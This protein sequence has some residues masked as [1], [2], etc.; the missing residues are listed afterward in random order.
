MLRKLRAHFR[1]I[2]NKLSPSWGLIVRVIFCFATGVVI[3]LAS[4]Q[5]RFD[6]RFNI[7]GSQSVGSEIVIITI[8]RDDIITATDF[9]DPN[10]KNILRSLK[11]V[12]DIN[13]AFYWNLSLWEKAFNKLQ[14][15]GAKAVV[16]TLV[17]GRDI[18]PG[19][20]RQQ[21]IFWAAKAEDEFL[22]QQTG[23]LDLYSDLD[24]NIRH[25]FGN[26]I[27]LAAKVAKQYLGH[28][29]HIPDPGQAINFQGPKGTFKTFTFADL[30]KGRIKESVLK[31][32]IV[33]LTAHELTTHQYSTPV[34]LLSTG[35][36]IANIIYNLIND[37]WIHELPWFICIL[38]LAII[39]G[40][41]LWI[42]FQYPE[43]V[44]LVFLGFL[45][46]AIIIS[47]VAFFDLKSIWLPLEAPM[48]L[49]VFTY[50]IITGYRL[51]ESEKH[52]WKSEQE[53]H[54]LSEV[55]SLK[56]NF[57]SLISHDL[58]NPLAKIQGITDR[59]MNDKD[60]PLSEVVKED[61]TTI[62]RTSDELRQYITSILQ[63]TRVEARDIKLNKEVCDINTVV[64]DVLARLKPLAQQKKI[65]IETHLEPIFSI[66]LDRSLICEVLI[67]LVENAIKYSDEGSKIDV[68]TSEVGNDVKVEVADN[69]GG[70]A[71]EEVPKIFDKFFR[72]KGDK[73][74]KVT[75]SG[76]GLYLVKYFIEL[77][78]GKVFINS[79]IGTG[80][81]IGFTLPLEQSEEESYAAKFARSHS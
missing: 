80:T 10:T 73:T 72:G 3:Y 53:L 43:S 37:N 39:L 14:T 7:R 51:G 6:T 81:K 79:H 60:S 65:I 36:T 45:A 32:K 19:L 12:G 49:I 5:S 24:G 52:S 58:K 20:S 31:N 25:Y 48:A 18:P 50:I 55:E 44:A 1:L 27:S 33:I 35:E 74:I 68:S 61:L 41:T 54:Y 17:L 30:I 71:E 42:I 40:L 9:L 66:E 64:E 62:R 78:G 47:S 15:T 75:G 67:N 2:K 69:A 8:S 13:D 16:V 26:N 22:G 38:F 23:Q 70:I 28:P 46:T 56:N 57:L 4:Q 76:L 77:H 63:L 34:G 29:A 11:E 59:L 21:N